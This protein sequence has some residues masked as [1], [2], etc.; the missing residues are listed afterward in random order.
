MPGSLEARGPRGQ[1][2]LSVTPFPPLPHP[3]CLPVSICH[4][5][6]TTQLHHTSIP[7]GT[8]TI[9]PQHGAVLWLRGYTVNRPDKR[10]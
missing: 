1:G 10:A 6:M 9:P 3:D 2:T 8:D 4:S 7:H 5:E